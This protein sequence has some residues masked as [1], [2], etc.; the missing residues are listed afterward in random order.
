[1]IDVRVG[2]ITASSLPPV[3]GAQ[4][5]SR[6]SFRPWNSPASIKIRFPEAVVSRCRDPVTSAPPRGR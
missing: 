4:F 2:E 3:Q 5:R 6:S 1:V